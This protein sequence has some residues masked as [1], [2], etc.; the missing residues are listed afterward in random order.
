MRLFSTLASLGLDPEKLI[1]TFGT[2]GLFAIIFAESGIMIGFFLPGDSLLFAAGLFS[3]RG[4][5]PN[6]A[7]ISIGC[8]IAAVA[9]DQVG[10]SFGKKVG[11]S[12]FKRPDSRFFKQE[13]LAKAEEFFEHY[14]SKAIILARFVPI[15]RTFVPI[16]AGASTMHYST[17]VRN[18]IVGGVVWAVGFTQLGFWLGKR[19][20]GLIDSI[21]ILVIVIV[22]F[23]LVPVGIEYWRHRRRS[24]KAR[25]AAS[26]P[27]ADD[28]AV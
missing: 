24:A 11:P 21:D 26:A 16:V 4:D 6:I 17:F 23:S 27:G 22:A 7:I 14:G 19:W 3:A 5:L 12:L 9:G 8:A 1:R 25:A 18:N 15:V 2:I 28:G 20:P 10:Y 13:Y